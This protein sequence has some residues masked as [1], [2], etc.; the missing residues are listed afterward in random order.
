MWV[1]PL[2][3]SFLYTL[4]RADSRP[5]FCAWN[6]KRD[7][8]KWNSTSSKQLLSSK[9]SSLSESPAPNDKRRKLRMIQVQTQLV[10]GSAMTL[11]ICLDVLLQPICVC[12]TWTQK[13]RL[14]ISVLISQCS[15]D[16]RSRTFIDHACRSSSLFAPAVCFQRMLW[17]ACMF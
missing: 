9:R 7:D 3:L 11:P 2:S 1:P 15:E 5:V 16:S 17:H 6:G 14:Y 8:E 13:E 12:S 4:M 10:S